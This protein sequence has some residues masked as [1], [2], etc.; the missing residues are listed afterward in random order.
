MS[1]FPDP[2][3]SQWTYHIYL[4]INYSAVCISADSAISDLLAS[5][6][7]ACITSIYS[8]FL[9]RVSSFSASKA[10]VGRKHQRIIPQDVVFTSFFIHILHLIDSIL[11]LGSMV[12]TLGI[13]WV[14]YLLSNCCCITS[15]IGVGSWVLG[16]EEREWDEV[17]KFK[18]GAA[19]GLKC[20]FVCI[21][22][23]GC[24]G[25]C[26]GGWRRQRMK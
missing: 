20:G 5:F 3:H 7:P 13:S 4:Y 22:C 17:W 19:K 2:L 26:W 12:G 6:T 11:D 18:E 15:H 14:E 23:L 21:T 25:W 10:L 24:E 8:H 16:L 1:H 9:A